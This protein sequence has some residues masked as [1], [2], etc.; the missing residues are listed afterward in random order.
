ME[1]SKLRLIVLTSL[2]VA[3][4]ATLL[5][6]LTYLQVFDN[7]KLVQTAN[8]QHLRDISIP[9]PRGRIVD[10][11]GQPLAEN[12]TSLVVS[13]NRSILLQQPDEGKAV[14]NRLAA[15]LG[16]PAKD[17][18]K[19]ITPCAPGV[20]KPCWTGSPYEPVPILTD[21]SNA[22]VLAISERREEFPGVEVGTQQVRTYPEKT[23]A[24]HEVGYVGPI[25]EDELDAA[26]KAG[27][28]YDGQDLVGR[29]GI[30]QTYDDELHGKNGTRTV[31]VDNVGDVT[32]LVETTAPTPG[33]T[34]ITSID[35]NVQRVA[36]K[37]LADQLARSRETFD[38]NTGKNFEAPSGAVVVLDAQTG[39]VL[40][41]ATNPT[42]D[43][44]V[45]IGGISQADFDRLTSPDSGD[46]L[47]S[48]ALQGQF[49]PGSTFK[50]STASGIVRDGQL[51]LDGVGTCPPYLQIGN[52][53]KTN[54][55]STSLAGDIPLDLALAFSC[56]T[57][58]Y[59]FAVD[60]WYA[61][62]ARVAEDKKPVEGLQDMARD[63]GF[64][65]KPGLDVPEG[66]QA[67]GSIVG[68]AEKKAR[69]DENKDEYCKAAKDGYP[70]VEDPVKREYFTLLAQENC[71]DGWRFTAGDAADL[72]IG[73]GEVTVSPLQLALAYG[74]LV[75]GGK[76]YEPTIGRA[77]VN[78]KGEVVREIK[79]QVRRQVD[80]DQEVLDYIRQSLTF[81]NG[82]SPSGEPA[83][84]G[85]PLEEYSIGGKTGTAEVYG[86]QDTSW[87]ASWSP[88]ENAEYVVVGMVEE[89]GLGSSAA[90]PMVRDVYEGIYGIDQPAALPGGKVPT[91]LPRIEPYADSG[92][93]SDIVDP[94][95]PQVTPSGFS[96]GPITDLPPAEPATRQVPSAR[97]RRTRS[98]EIA[99]SARFRARETALTAISARRRWRWRRRW[100]T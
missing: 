1:R 62:Q 16:R 43:P 22:D 5:V 10:D 39:R 44:N 100:S 34:L 2:V 15:L 21:A 4:F 57:F 85:F 20:E 28:D 90:A 84:S 33:N 64:G 36:E 92:V 37:A 31:S 86:K 25:T 18:A 53:Q 95:L 59:K 26:E 82:L 96:L 47:I 77:I 24:S 11:R 51:P 3:L 35:A 9:A 63:Y 32:G 58:F 67:A 75:N 65:E 60:A 17:I 88:A 49:S 14:L 23:L 97:T 83:F 99:L 48:R 81:G 8:A 98:A 6:R 30:E 41:A 91:E 45:F 61:D 7:E 71:T 94:D 73:Q 70:N 76:L 79:P 54:Y 80:V 66:E 55:D 72:S 50:L 52:Q 42:Y 12:R 13:V 19:E 78:P 46:P 93:P 38:D 27:K 56:D 40:G 74:A 68:R 89:A 87:F 29:S 69:W